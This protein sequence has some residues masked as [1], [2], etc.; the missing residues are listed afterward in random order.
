MGSDVS[1]TEAFYNAFDEESLP[2]ALNTS[3]CS[4]KWRLFIDSSKVILK[5]V[6]LHNGNV[7]PSIPV[8]H[9]FGIKECD[10]SMKQLLQYIKYD[11]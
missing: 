3:H 11:T 8:A 5:P 2:L 7:L 1:V 6:L 4:D 9:A 10:D